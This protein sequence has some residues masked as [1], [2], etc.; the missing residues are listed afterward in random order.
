MNVQG[1]VSTVLGVKKAWRHEHPQKARVKAGCDSFLSRG[2]IR[3]DMETIPAQKGCSSIPMDGL[4]ASHIG[5]A[6][7]SIV[8]RTQSPKCVSVIAS[9]VDPKSNVLLAASMLHCIYHSTAQ[10]P[11]VS[12]RDRRSMFPYS[13]QEAEKGLA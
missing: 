10:G 7:I 9:T 4:I 11:L 1:E 5:L 12:H 6:L 3:E 2:P 8:S 13:R